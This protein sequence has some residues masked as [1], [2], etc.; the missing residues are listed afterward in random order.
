MSRS[1]PEPENHA[2]GIPPSPRSD[3]LDPGVRLVQHE[4]F[5]KDRARQELG[6]ARIGIVTAS[7]VVQDTM[8]AALQKEKRGPGPAPTPAAEATYLWTTLRNKIREAYRTAR[9]VK[10]GGSVKIDSLVGD[11]IASPGTSPSEKYTRK[12]REEVLDRAMGLLDPKDQEV[13]TL[14]LVDGKSNQAIGEL[15]GV[16]ARHVG[17]LYEK[18]LERL[19]AAYASEGGALDFS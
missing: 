16:S 4:P 8:V 3:D 6:A 19:R 15:L 5:V 13:L 12:T 2:T 1:S 18:A 10:R 14:K 7:D 11:A 17:N 9:A